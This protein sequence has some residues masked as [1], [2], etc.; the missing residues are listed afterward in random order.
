MGDN[1]QKPMLFVKVEPEYTA[2]GVRCVNLR[3]SIL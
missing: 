2:E 1:L 3:V